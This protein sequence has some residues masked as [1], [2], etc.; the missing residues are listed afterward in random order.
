MTDERR[1]IEQFLPVREVSRES[2]REK[3]AGRDYHLSTLHSWWARR[4]LAAARAAVIA[5]LLPISA[6]PAERE[7]LELFF[8]AL[9]T[10]R[11]DEIGLNPR[12]LSTARELIDKYWGN[13]RPRVLDSFAGGG[14]IPLEILRLGGDATAVELNPVAWVVAAGTVVWPQ[15]FGP[16]LADD[17]ARWGK[18]VRDGA[19]REVADLYPPLTTGD[20]SARNKQLSFQ[21]DGMMR[22]LDPRAYLW[23]RTV[24]CPNPAL[25]P[26]RA[27]L[28]RSKF[29]VN[30]DAKRIALKITP[31][32]KNGGVRYELEAGA[33]AASA[34]RRGRSSA[35]ACR[36]CG[37]V[38]P[39]KYLE[40]EGDAGGLGFDLVAVVCGAAGQRGKVYLA[41]EAAGASVPN[42]EAVEDHIQRLAVEGLVVPDEVIQPM[43][44]AGLASGATYLYGIKTFGDVFTRRQLATLLTLCKHVRR[45]HESM[46]AEG[47][48]EHRAAVVSAYVAMAVDRVAERSTALTRWNLT[49]EKAES[50]FVRDRLAMV[51]DFVEV[52]PFGGISGDM[53]AS[54][55][56]V[57]KV[58]RHCAR[59]DRSADLRRGTAT[60]LP[61]RANTF[62]A[63]VVDPPYYDNI[64]YANSSDF[65]YVWLKRSIGH[66]FPEH[67]SGPVAPKRH[68][69]V[70]AAYRHG[71]D[72]EAAAREYEDLMTRAFVELQR[73]LKVSAPLVV[74]YAHQ[75]TAGWSTLIRGLTRSGF[76][77]VEAW[78]IDTEMGERRGGR[79]NASLASSI[80]LVARRRE[81]DSTGSWDEV[82]VEMQAIVAERVRSL[83]AMGVTGADLVIS[84]IGAGLRPYT[85]HAK[86]ELAN[87]M[88]IEAEAYLDEVQ[89]EVIK[90]ILSDVMGVSRSGVEAVDPVTQLYVIGR[91]EYGDT[92][93][94]FDELNTLAHGVLAGARARGKELM[95]PRSL[96]SGPDALVV[97][98]GD[99][100]RLRDYEERGSADR[101]GTAE[102]GRPALI[103]VLQRLVWLAEHDPGEVMAF[104]WGA[105]PDHARLQMVARA[106]TGATLS[107]KGMGTSDREKA[108]MQRLLA[109]WKRIVEEVLSRAR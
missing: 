30:K 18:W 106:L 71:K 20:A 80:F 87:G 9:T 68:E 60:D 31:D 10:W 61:F 67:F 26:H 8:S 102:E 44:N 65:Y 3:M 39:A 54:V 17:V 7:K 109:A 90:T 35:S 78:P 50:P 83:P 4:P 98:D 95:G 59:I 57:V 97:Q 91:F 51:W 99:I 58:I 75:T 6:F 69:I 107:G 27:P 104:L 23:T 101:L 55:D 22:H 66:L 28:I 11:G 16:S 84:A 15:A 63:A 89:T 14:A 86:V 48:D 105:Q 29:V 25:G 52:N 41:G 92:F 103:D 72:K 45:A 12:I 85:R 2:A 77:V 64:S 76:M 81:S 93:V 24:T 53:G 96:A 43:G 42:I 13:E 46:I 47:M 36:I 108:A 40:A 70:A 74:V 82:Q 37:A 73:V 56:S 21:G 38:I 33:V 88:P 100:V 79:N 1:L 34:E 49:G 32:P 94:P 19:Q 5:T 62:D